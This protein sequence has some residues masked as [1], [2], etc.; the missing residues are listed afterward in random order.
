MREF[1]LAEGGEL[2]LAA[3]TRPGSIEMGGISYS[4]L[5]SEVPE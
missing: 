5:V 3:W 2:F 1:F 4:G